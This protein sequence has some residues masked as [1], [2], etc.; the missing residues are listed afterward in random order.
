[1]RKNLDIH[2]PNTLT[3]RVRKR[4]QDFYCRGDPFC[5]PIITILGLAE[6]GGDLFSEGGEDSLGGIAGLK[7][8][9]ER[10]RS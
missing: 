3:K 8:G 7:G 6:R 9:K 4:I 5:E 1:M 2:Q 10:M